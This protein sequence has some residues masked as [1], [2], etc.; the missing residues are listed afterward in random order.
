MIVDFGGRMENIDRH[1]AALLIKTVS[2]LKKRSQ[3]DLALKCGVN[4]RHL[5]EFLN[6][7]IDL[8]PDQI[9]RLLDELDLREKAVEL[10]ASA[11]WVK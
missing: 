5:N 11:E 9:E 10:S 1:K 8:L 6:R 4:R 3:Y 2:V 7:H